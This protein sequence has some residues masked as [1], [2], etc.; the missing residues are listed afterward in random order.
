V[1]PLKD[2]IAPRTGKLRRDAAVR[3]GRSALRA[4][5]VAVAEHS[6]G[7]SR[8]HQRGQFPGGFRRR[9]QKQG[10]RQQRNDGRL[11]LA[12]PHDPESGT[13]IA[14]VRMSVWSGH[15]VDYGLAIGLSEGRR[16]EAQ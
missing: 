5:P 4:P 7:N 10:D 9:E 1:S 8:E 3:Q 12:P 2:G 16:A 13:L 15:N 11:C 6:K 14:V